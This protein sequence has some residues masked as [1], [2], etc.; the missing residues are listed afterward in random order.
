MIFTT[1]TTLPIYA[2]PIDQ[3]SIKQRP[4]ILSPRD[5]PPAPPTKAPL[6]PR[7]LALEDP[8]P[9]AAAIALILPLGHA[10]ADAHH[11]DQFRLDDTAY[12][13]D[14]VARIPR[15]QNRGGAI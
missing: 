1:V 8:P 15:A 11:P 12:P 3:F 7:D 13:F 5:N 2:S 14:L 6:A 10:R 9:A 4:L